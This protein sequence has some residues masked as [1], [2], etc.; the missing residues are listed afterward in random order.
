M[1]YLTIDYSPDTPDVKEAKDNCERTLAFLPYKPDSNQIPKHFL[2]SYSISVNRAIS[3][4]SSC[5][6]RCFSLSLLSTFILFTIL[7]FLLLW[8]IPANAVK[9]ES[10]RYNPITSRSTA[11]SSASAFLGTGEQAFSVNLSD[12]SVDPA[13]IA[14]NK[15]GIVLPLSFP[16]TASLLHWESISGGYVARFRVS[17]NDQIKRVRLHLTFEDTIP[18]ISFRMQGNLDCQ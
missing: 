9:V 11:T 15:S 8:T 4:D 16:I 5:S 18:I 7:G 17:A 6:Y 10:T 1:N 3:Q 14:G 13:T 12:I 2:L